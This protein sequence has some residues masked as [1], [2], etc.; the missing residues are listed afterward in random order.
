MSQKATIIQ[1]LED[2]GDRGVTSQEFYDVFL[3]RFAARIHELKAD[4]YE[5]ADEPE[6]RFKRY[7]LRASTTPSLVGSKGIAV[8]RPRQE[9]EQPDGV[10]HTPSGSPLLSGSSGEVGMNNHD[11]LGDCSTVAYSSVAATCGQAG[12][13]GRAHKVESVEPLNVVEP[14]V[15][16]GRSCLNPYEYEAEAA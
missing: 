16:S 10:T 1:M 13:D 8:G 4:G 15:T 12:G 7:K 11:T 5:I 2:A 9:P 6:G 14:P 3:P